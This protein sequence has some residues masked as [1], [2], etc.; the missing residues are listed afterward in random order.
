MVFNKL[1]LPLS[2]KKTASPSNVLEYLGLILDS[3]RMEALL[4]LDKVSRITNIIKSFQSRTS[5]TKQ[6]LLSLLG[7]LNF[8]CRVIHPGPAFVPY[9][10]GLFFT[11][12]ELHHH[13]KI[14]TKCCWDLKMESIFLRLWNGIS[15]FLDDEETTAT[16]LQFLTDA[17]L[18]CF[19]CYYGGK[20]FC[21]NS[22]MIS[23]RRTARHR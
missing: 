23:F 1:R 21:G 14:T 12:K 4:P 9:L 10:I 22:T 18:S 15:F 17:T 11:V 2:A 19:W 8:S 3:L 16:Q 6:E 13:V 5:C 20:W 7:H